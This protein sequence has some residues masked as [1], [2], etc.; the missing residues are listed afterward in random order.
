[1]N[2]LVERE[3]SYMYKPVSSRSDATG[4]I[5]S[6]LAGCGRARSVASMSKKVG[7]RGNV[8]SLGLGRL[9]LPFPGWV[10]GSTASV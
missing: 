7:V 6:K 2:G 8:G 5:D 9:Y 4:R 3:S 10:T 1:M